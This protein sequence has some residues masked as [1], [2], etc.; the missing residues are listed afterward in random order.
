MVPGG[1]QAEHG[2]VAMAN[3][4]EYKVIELREKLIGGK[5]SGGRLEKILNEHAA[6]GWQLKAITAT[7]VKGRVGPGGVEGLLI[8]F[9][10]LVG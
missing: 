5:M 9:E 6:D 7:E 2:G 4:Y 3:R 8:T 10:R 1:D